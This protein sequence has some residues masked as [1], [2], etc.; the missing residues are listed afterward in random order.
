MKKYLVLSLIVSLSAFYTFAQKPN[1]DQY[2]KGKLDKKL[3]SIKSLQIPTSAGKNVLPKVVQKKPDRSPASINGN[4]DV[5]FSAA[6]THSGGMNVSISDP[7][8][9]DCID[10]S[11]V[12]KKV[13]LNDPT[14]SVFM[15]FQIDKFDLDPFVD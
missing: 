15:N 3:L 1:Y 14:Q 12:A 6:C 5:S 11:S 7:A 4:I 10:E 13:I 9:V 8:Y 2:Q